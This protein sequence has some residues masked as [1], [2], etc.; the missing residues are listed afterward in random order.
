MTNIAKPIKKSIIIRIKSKPNF[1]S[2]ED[3]FSNEI[4]ETEE[5]KSVLKDNEKES[6]SESGSETDGVWTWDMKTN[7]VFF[8][9]QWKAIFGYEDSEICNTL[10]EW[11]QRVHPDDLELTLQAVE[12]YMNDDVDLYQSMH[13]I[14]CKDGNYIWVLDEG[15]IID[16]EGVGEVLL[17]V[18]THLNITQHRKRTSELEERLKELNC[19]NQISKIL[20]EPGLSTDEVINEI[21][22]IIPPGMQF[23]YLAEASVIIN[24]QAYQ[25]PNF[26]KSNYLLKQDIK[27][28][29]KIIGRIEVCYP[30]D[31]IPVVDP[32]F[33][34]EETELLFSVAERIGKFIE[35]KENETALNQS[36]DKFRMMVETIDEIIYDFSVDGLVNYISPSVKRI[37]GFDPEELIGKKIFDI[38]HEADRAILAERLALPDNHMS[39]FEYRF[40]TKSGEIRW[41]RKSTVSL[42]KEEYLISKVGTLTDITESKQTKDF[43]NQLLQLSPKLTCTTISE[44]DNTLNLVLNKIGEFLNA[45]RAYIFEFS[46][47]E[48]TFSNTYEWCSKDI[49]PEIRNMQEIPAKFFPMLISTLQNHE[50]IL[51][52]SAF[53]LPDSW[54]AEREFFLSRSIRSMILIP[55]FTE[56]KMLGFVGLDSVLNQKVY[57]SSEINNLKIWSSLIG[58]LI[59]SKRIERAFQLQNQ[60]WAFWFAFYQK[61]QQ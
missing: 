3:Q 46:A 22:Q 44:I 2:S 43:E 30:D 53:D 11:T 47:D 12:R 4:S 27:L 19:H 18:G 35:K 55:I 24:D 21:V 49:H 6:H 26:K 61:L 56:E 60:T 33:L 29:N 23:P 48:S 32:V 36:E 1:D 57:T 39:S 59:N 10:E 13:R 37:L 15:K 42:R 31:Q 58:S 16:Y 7:Q 17:V 41:L 28:K 54:H 52:P 20:A 25:T 8:S 51:I 9:K 38:V 40:I 5:V 14:K 45:G 50:D 34:M